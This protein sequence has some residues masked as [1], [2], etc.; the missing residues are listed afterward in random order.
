[1]PSI[2]PYL[3]FPGTTEDSLE[4]ADRLFKPLSNVGVLEMP[5][6]DMI[7]GAY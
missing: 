6:T 2:N 4:K 7:W 1:M 3:N 5:L